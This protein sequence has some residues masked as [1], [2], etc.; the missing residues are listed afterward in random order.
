M[1]SNSLTTLLDRNSSFAEQFEAGDLPIRPRMP[2]IVLTC[3]DA[4]I[5]PAHLFGLE[6]G[7]AL[8]MRNAGGRI[9][10]AVLKDLAVLAVL[11]ANMPGPSKMKTELV[12]LHH[13]DCG[14]S[15]FTNPELQRQAAE[16]LDRSIDEI[17]AMAITDPAES[18]QFDIK[19]LRSTLSAPEQLVV[20]GLVYDVKTGAINQVAPPTP[21]HSVG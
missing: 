14:M 11:G 9:T 21:L 12:I 4:R 19:R 3:L 20:S 10:S 2:T 1:I 13:T 17:A 16:R 8:V 6:L 15:R 5:D 7:D 18:V